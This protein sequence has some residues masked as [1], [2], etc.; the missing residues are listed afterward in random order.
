M[1]FSEAFPAYLRTES[2]L[3]QANKGKSITFAQS[4]FGNIKDLCAQNIGERW[5]KS[6]VIC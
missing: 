4:W 6:G 3:V 1:S 2:Q 5:E